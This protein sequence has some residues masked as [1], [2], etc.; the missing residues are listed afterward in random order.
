MKSRRVEIFCPRCAWRPKPDS[1]WTCKPACGNI[2]NTFETAGICPA[3][4]HA[5]ATTQ[6]LA[7]HISSP[8]KDWYHETTGGGTVTR[9]TKKKKKQMA[10]AR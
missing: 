6:C 2:W 3:C 4:G 9:E 8:H 1:R 7:C 5:W 10:G